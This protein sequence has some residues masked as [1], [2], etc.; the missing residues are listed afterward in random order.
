MNIDTAGS[1]ESIALQI[2]NDISEDIDNNDS[3][4]N[5]RIAVKWWADYACEQS[6]LRAEL[7]QKEKIWNGIKKLTDLL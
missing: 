7:E 5:L 4:E 2:S 3:K 1:Q 6:R